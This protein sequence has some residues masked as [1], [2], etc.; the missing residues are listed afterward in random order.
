VPGHR[1]LSHSCLFAGGLLIITLGVGSRHA[2]A[3]RDVALPGPAPRG[4]LPQDTVRANRRCALCHRSIVEEWKRSLHRHSYDDPYFARALRIEPVNFCRKCHA[5]D[6]D[7]NRDP[8]PAIAADGVSCLTCHWTKVGVVGAHGTGNQQIVDHDASGD[9]RLGDDRACGNCHQFDFPTKAG[10]V[11]VTPMQDTVREHE[12]SAYPGIPCQGCHMPLVNDSDGTKHHRHDFAVQGDRGFLAHAVRIE[13]VQ[14]TPNGVTVAL[15]SGRIGHAFP[16]GDL[17]RSAELELWTSASPG[18]K[19]KP[20]I[21]RLERGYTQDRVNQARH[22]AGDTRLVP[23]GGNRDSRLIKVPLQT[24]TEPIHYRLTWL[25]MPDG[26]AK[27][28]SFDPL[29]QRQVILEGTL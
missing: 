18:R 10:A 6:A 25:R 17:F 3:A 23:K 12:A 14:R 15:F 5:A 7:P 1:A 28:L 16:T 26:L 2:D 21:V 24:S 22:V 27:L 9:A 13:L 29:K 11:S 4:N 20:L 8:D 19:A